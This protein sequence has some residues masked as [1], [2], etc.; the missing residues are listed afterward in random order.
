MSNSSLIPGPVPGAWHPAFLA[1]LPAIR[2]A[3]GTAFRHLHGDHR[4]EAVQ[5][6]VANACAAFAR[7][8]E[9][10]C[11][12]RAFPSVLARFAVA[13]V[14][15]GRSI[16]TPLNIRDVSSP[17]ARRR[18]RCV[19]ERLDRFD[20]EQGH[21]EEAVVEDSRTAVAEQ[22][23]FR[24]DFP[25]WLSRL[26]SRDRRIAEALSVGHTTG[27]VARRSGVSAG[28]VAQLRRELHDSWRR[29]HGEAGSPP[30]QARGLRIRP[31]SAVT[32]GGPAPGG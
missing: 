11:P 19:V 30:L 3:V 13:Q 17:Y 7:L 14:R 1:M 31:P 22:A 29:F 24:I 25:E 16:G 4:D 26:S 27:D 15:E 23:W 5:E 21:W 2:R 6:A 20:G 32:T 28:R 18:K 10:G 12:E 9:R 8:F